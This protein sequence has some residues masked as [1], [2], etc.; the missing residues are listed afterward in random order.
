MIRVGFILIIIATLAAC[1]PVRRDDAPADWVERKQQLLT[2]STWSLQGRISLQQADQGFN[3]SLRW[4]QTDDVMQADFS[5]PFGAGAFRIS[6]KP[7]ALLLQSGD[8]EYYLPDDP[9]A[10]L[11]DEL[12]WSVPLEAMPYWLVGVAHPDLPARHHFGADGQLNRIEQLDWQISYERFSVSD[13]WLMPRKMRLQGDNDVR[14]KLIVSRWDIQSQ[15]DTSAGTVN[16]WQML[17]GQN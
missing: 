5:G 4:Q 10:A 8:S 11:D 12:G 2:L 3:G 13:G 14:I 1:A 9:Q 7:D 15:P 17:S 16:N 6:G